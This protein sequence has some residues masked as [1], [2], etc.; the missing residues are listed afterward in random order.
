MYITYSGVLNKLL[1]FYCNLRISIISIS[2][3]ASMELRAPD[4]AYWLVCRERI[5]SRATEIYTI[6]CF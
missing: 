6:R 5:H 4:D 2:T 1:S 3:E